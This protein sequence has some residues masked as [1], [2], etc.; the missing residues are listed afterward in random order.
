MVAGVMCSVCR[1]SVVT[2]VAPSFHVQL[3]FVSEIMLGGDLFKR[4]VTARHFS[5]DV[6]RHFFHAMLSAVSCL[7]AANV[8]HLCVLGHSLS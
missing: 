3:F 1:G 6:A 8:V 5:E 2:G 7:H 4:L